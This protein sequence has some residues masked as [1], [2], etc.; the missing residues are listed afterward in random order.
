MGAL[1][2]STIILVTAILVVVIPKWLEPNLPP[3]VEGEFHPE[4]MEVA[5]IFR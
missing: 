3:I 1:K 4:F 5:E 2:Q